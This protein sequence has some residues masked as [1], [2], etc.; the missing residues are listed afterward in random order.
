L[1]GAALAAAFFAGA[2]VVRFTGSSAVSLALVATTATLSVSRTSV[3]WAC[4]TEKRRLSNIGVDLRSDDH[5]YPFRRPP[6]T[7]VTT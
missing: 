7:I 4:A 1:A 3:A 6:L 2:L 5:R